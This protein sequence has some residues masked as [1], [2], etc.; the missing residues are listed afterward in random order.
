MPLNSI[1]CLIP[2]YPVFLSLNRITFSAYASVGCRCLAAFD[3]YASTSRSITLRRWSCFKNVYRFLIGNILLWACFALPNF[4]FFDLVSITPT[5]VIC[6]ISKQ[7]YS[8]Y[9]AYFVNPVLYFALPLIL[10]IS[11]AIQTHRNLRLMNTTRRLKKLERQ[12]CSVRY[13]KLS[14]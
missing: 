6:H 8:H 5:R 11:L 9:F 13:D 12:M 2:R 4:L 7:I 1:V 10:L 14:L 3:R